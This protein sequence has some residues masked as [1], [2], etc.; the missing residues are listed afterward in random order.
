MVPR[1]VNPARRACL[2]VPLPAKARRE[3]AEVV[4]SGRAGSSLAASGHCA[5]R[6]RRRPV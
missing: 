4:Q 6:G 1:A 3:A 2:P 5:E